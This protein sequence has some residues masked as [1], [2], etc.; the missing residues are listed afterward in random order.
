M[1][2][3]GLVRAS[4]LLRTQ[5][6]RPSLFW[7]QVPYPPLSALAAVKTFH[8]EVITLIYSLDVIGSLPRY[9]IVSFLHTELCFICRIGVCCFT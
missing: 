5:I 4:D 3:Q 2:I 6:P 8:W 1:E 7:Y 9:I